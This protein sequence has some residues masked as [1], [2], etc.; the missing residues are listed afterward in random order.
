[1]E[2]SEEKLKVWN[3]L[4]AIQYLLP[5]F[6]IIPLERV[7]IPSYC[8]SVKVKQMW[9]TTNKSIGQY[10]NNNQIIRRK[11]LNQHDQLSLYKGVVDFLLDTPLWVL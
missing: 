5:Q 8:N 10:E 4:I 2:H 11:Y 9:Q 6:Q 1:M 7:Y 3:S